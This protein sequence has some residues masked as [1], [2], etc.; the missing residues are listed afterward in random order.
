MVDRERQGGQV[1]RDYKQRWRQNVREGQEED[2]G[3]RT[4]NREGGEQIQRGTLTIRREQLEMC[5]QM[6]STQHE[7]Q[8]FLPGL[9]WQV[10]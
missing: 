6:A 7:T 8:H 2:K 10:R 9:Q 1:G 5:T 3:K 4:E